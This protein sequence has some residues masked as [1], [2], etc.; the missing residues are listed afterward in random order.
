MCVRAFARNNLLLSSSEKMMRNTYIYSSR[1]ERK[2]REQ[3]ED[4]WITKENTRYI[5]EKEL[6]KKWK[7][8]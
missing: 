3:R 8:K 2:E 6:E 7:M 4:I 1:E 5:T